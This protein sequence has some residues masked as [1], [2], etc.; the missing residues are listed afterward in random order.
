MNLCKAL[1]V[2]FTLALIAGCAA[3]EEKA[4]DAPIA[5]DAGVLAGAPQWVFNPEREG[6]ITEIGSAP[7]SLGGF[8]AQRTEALGNARDALARLLSV[9]VQNSLKNFSQQT[10]VGDD[11]T[12][13]KV[14][15]STS[16][17]LAKVELNGAGQKELWIGKDG[18]MYVLVALESDK[19]AAA[20]KKLAVSSFKN[21]N[22]LWQQ[23][24]A[25][26][27]Q[28]QLSLEIE[29]EFNKQ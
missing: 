24:Q 10:G 12:M 1:I 20:M 23:F 16:N 13:D 11:Q 8:Q 5:G 15:V 19:V 26:K 18:T 21:E 9:K 29:K 7:K 28:D 3:T 4:A 6:L 2:L 27:A 14:V 17:Q 25:Q 22:A